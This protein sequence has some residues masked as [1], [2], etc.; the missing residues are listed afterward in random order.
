MPAIDQI[1]Q[2]VQKR[3]TKENGARVSAC[4]VEITVIALARKRN[5][6]RKK[7][8]RCEKCKLP[9]SRLP[10]LESS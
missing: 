8:K 4:V 6:K 2:A 5:E 1:V 3:L 7:K 9:C 10:K